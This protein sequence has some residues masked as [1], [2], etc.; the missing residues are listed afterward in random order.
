VELESPADDQAE[1]IDV[2]GLLVEIVGAR[3]DRPQG[4]LACSVTGGDDHLGFGLE[5]QD[6]FKRGKAL[7]HAIRIR[8]ETKIERDHGGLGRAN[9][10]EGRIAVGGDQHL[11]IVIGPTQLTLQALVILDDQHGFTGMFMRIRS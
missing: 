9:Q 8:G 10:V 11:I 7:A 4:A 2:D 3:G 1:L 6:M 5:R